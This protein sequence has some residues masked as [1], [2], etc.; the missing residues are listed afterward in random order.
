MTQRGVRARCGPKV[1]PADLPSTSSP[2]LPGRGSPWRSCVRPAPGEPGMRRGFF[3]G[4]TPSEGPA[5]CQTLSRLTRSNATAPDET[6]VSSRK[7][8]WRHR[9]GAEAPERRR[10]LD[11]TG[12][13]PAGSPPRRRFPMTAAEGLPAWH[14]VSPRDNT[15]PRCGETGSTRHRE[16]GGGHGRRRIAGSGERTIDDARVRLVVVHGAW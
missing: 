6:G 1:A 2:V 16:T 4:G 12:R 15:R 5:L 10:Q 13:G 7:S 11:G 9:T 3:R 14:R 8:R